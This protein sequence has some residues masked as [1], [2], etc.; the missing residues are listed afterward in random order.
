MTGKDREMDVTKIEYCFRKGKHRAEARIDGDLY[1]AWADTA[2]IARE[3][4]IKNIKRDGYRV[5][6]GI[7]ALVAER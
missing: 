6:S 7:T 3:R 1:L 2:Q 5:R 4:M